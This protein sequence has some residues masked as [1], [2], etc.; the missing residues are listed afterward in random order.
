[1]SLSH[2]TQSLYL[3]A[4]E[5]DDQLTSIAVAP[6]DAAVSAGAGKI[7][8]DSVCAWIAFCVVEGV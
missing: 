1:M 5:T 7:A 3:Y 6:E 8:G 2:H 4:P